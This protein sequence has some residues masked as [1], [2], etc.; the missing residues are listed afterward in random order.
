MHTGSALRM[1]LMLQSYVVTLLHRPNSHSGLLSA[2]S[3][4]RGS[5]ITATRQREYGS[6]LKTSILP[7]LSNFDVKMTS[8]RRV[9]FGSARIFSYL[10][11]VES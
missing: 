2:R 4:T 11:S 7:N 5:K 6:M 10:C 8:N 9:K 3:N 1:G